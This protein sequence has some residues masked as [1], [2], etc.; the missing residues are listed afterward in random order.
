M[1]FYSIPA[2]LPF[3]TFI[4]LKQPNLKSSWPF[5]RGIKQNKMTLGRRVA[6]RGRLKEVAVE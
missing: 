3:V 2:T 1:C 6:G 5:N 4:L